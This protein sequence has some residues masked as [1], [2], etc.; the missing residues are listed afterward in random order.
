MER[1]NEKNAKNVT[2]QKLNEDEITQVK[3]GVG[4]LK[5]DGVEGECIDK[6]HTSFSRPMKSGISGSTR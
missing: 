2:S 5:F 4:Y 3:G 1:T 6:A